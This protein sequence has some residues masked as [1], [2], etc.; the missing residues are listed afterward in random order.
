MRDELLYVFGDKHSDGL[1]LVSTI[2]DF[3]GLFPHLRPDKK[4]VCYYF[5]SLILKNKWSN[6]PKLTT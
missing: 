2:P 5:S 3:S 6:I 1:C 4:N